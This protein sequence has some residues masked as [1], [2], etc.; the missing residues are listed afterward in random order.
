MDQRVR[1]RITMFYLAGFINALLGLYVLFQGA[2]FL[3]SDKVTMLSFLF[4]I[5]AA[6]DFYF[7]QAIKKKW[8][9][10]QEKAAQAQAGQQPKS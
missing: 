9:K 1:K 8:R 3:P 7:P 6:V 2:S 4:F 10:D 5:F